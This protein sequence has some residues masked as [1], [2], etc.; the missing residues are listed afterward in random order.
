MLG[1][2]LT[3]CDH[4]V[5]YYYVVTSSDESGAAWTIYKRDYYRPPWELQYY[6]DSTAGSGS[7]VVVN[8]YIPGGIS[9]GTSGIKWIENRDTQKRY[10][11]EYGDGIELVVGPNAVN[12]DD[13]KY[14]FFYYTVDN[15]SGELNSYLNVNGNLMTLDSDERGLY[16]AIY[17]YA[18]NPVFIYCYALYVSNTEEIIKVVC[19]NYYEGS[20]STIEFPSSTFIENGWFSVE[21]SYTRYGAVSNGTNLR[22]A[23]WSETR[24]NVVERTRNR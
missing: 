9:G 19:K 14:V 17:E 2:T 4:S 5:S 3:I 11:E 21:D 23:K 16:A 20:E 13:N 8:T 10:S 15:S 12:A 24:S 6:I 1:G 18:G 7:Y 22:A